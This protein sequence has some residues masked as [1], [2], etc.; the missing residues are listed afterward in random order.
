MMSIFYKFPAQTRATCLMI[1][2]LLMFTVMG[3]CIRLSAEHLPVIEVVF[4]RNFLAVLILLPLVAHV[5]FGSLQMRRPKLF[6][7]RAAVNAVG[8]FCGF[9][10]LTL[11]P[12]AQMT[13]L[14]FTTPLFVTIGAVLFLGEIIRA[15]RIA[16]ICIGFLGTLIILQPGFVDL[17]AGSFLALVHAL[18][19]AMASLIVKVLTRSDSQ[20]A[21]VTWMVV[22]Q[23]PLAL[24]PSLW[25]W[26]WPDL[27][28][29]GF[30]WGMALS[31]TIAHLC[32]TR[33]FS[34]VDI[35]ALQPLEFIKLPF[36]VILAW[37]VFAE[38]PGLWTFVGGAVIFA[39]TVYITRREAATRGSTQLTA[40]PGEP[41]L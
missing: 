19:I 4:F 8:M 18:T 28:T 7:V 14:S 12:L 21:I 32:F 23:T 13:A 37:I 26:E 41:R 2:A 1:V 29:W 34:L 39:S 35:T 17:T 16:A 27:L 6:V 11:I 31:G 24:F 20:H 5:G 10:A 3:I 33:A 36:A 40:G 38:L 30:L 15:R 25:V 9:T 22:M